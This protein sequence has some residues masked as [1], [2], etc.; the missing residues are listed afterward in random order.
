MAG[1]QVAVLTSIGQLFHSGPVAGLDDGERQQ[2]ADLMRILLA[3]FDA[4]E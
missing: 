1:R 3:P 4:A 2:L